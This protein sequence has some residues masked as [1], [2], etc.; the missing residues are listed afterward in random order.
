M[1]DSVV[2]INVF[3]HGL[4]AGAMLV[5]ALVVGL[6]RLGAHVR[7]AAVMT[8]I[9]IAAWLLSEQPA[10]FAAVGD[11]WLLC[12]L[13]YPVSG[14]FWLFVLTIF[15]EARVTPLTLA[16][17]AIL[18]V[19]GFMMRASTPPAFDVIWSARNLF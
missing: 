17:A 18:L 7:L 6:S 4:A 19:S 16:P 11:S 2:L 3:V 1:T 12:A 13:N 8:A 5:M 10:L 14:L 15:A 9:S